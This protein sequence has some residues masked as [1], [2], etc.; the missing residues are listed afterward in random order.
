MAKEMLENTFSAL[1]SE[2]AAITLTLLSSPSTGDEKNPAVD[3]IYLPV[4][5]I[6]KENYHL[7]KENR[8]GFVGAA[9][10]AAQK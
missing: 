9:I 6:G 4:T 2:V 7:V 1:R 10:S 8:G 5:H 3:A